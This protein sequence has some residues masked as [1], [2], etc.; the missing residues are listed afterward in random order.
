MGHHQGFDRNARGGPH[1]RFAALVLVVL[2]VLPVALPAGEPLTDAR[3]EQVRREV[4]DLVG[5]LDSS[6]YEVRQRAAQ[7]LD[8]LVATPALATVL[9]EEFQRLVVQPDLPFEARWRLNRW[10][11]RLPNGPATAGRTATPAELDHLVAQIDDDSFAVRQGAVQRLQW[12]AGDATLSGPI[13]LRLKQRMTDPHLSVETYQQLDAVRRTVWSTWLTS[14]STDWNLPSAS[15]E[16]LQRWIDDLVRPAP[17]AAKG[18]AWLR[19]QAAREELMDQL[20]LDA[21]VPKLKAA[22]ESRLSDRLESDAASR[23][24][25]LLDLTR[26]AMVAEFWFARRPSGEQ[27]LFV[28]VPSQVAGALRPSHFDRIDDRVAHCVSGNSLSPGDYPVGVAFPHP[29]QGNAFFHLVNLSTP[30]RQIAYSHYTKTEPAARLTAIS[31]RTL[32]RFLAEKHRLNDAEIGMLGQLDPKE[33]SRFAGQYFLRVD[34]AQIDDDDAPQSVMIGRPRP[35]GQASR[36]GMICAQLAGDGTREA[37]PGLLEAIRQ[38]RFLPPTSLG[39][40]QLHW[41]AALAI[42]RREPWP[43]VESWLVDQLGNSEIM[44]LGRS[45]GPEVG[46]AAAGLLLKRH[47]ERPEAFGLESAPE[48]LLTSFGIAGYRFRS[49]ADARRV[50]AW[51]KKAEG[52]RRKAEVRTRSD[53][54]LRLRN[55]RPL[56][57]SQCT[58]PRP[59][60]LRS[61]KR[62]PSAFRL[63]F[64]S[65]RLT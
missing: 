4:A 1:R 51:W 9:A 21:Q 6:R 27:H 31:R 33:V 62:P 40:Y 39:P 29:A 53:R 20:A 48:S 2:I 3:R 34:D 46:A 50:E 57:A 36:H 56:A 8:E 63:P 49:P 19:Q 37:I 22:L 41:L 61:R 28:G 7:R 16:Q 14:D 24:K 38:K 23:L 47:Q 55:V 25:E 12:L 10:R 60:A 44:V 42:A 5:G 32:D 26:P 13:M 54:R 15:Q 45:E 64:P 30:R 43:E 59:R 35:G 11:T 58:W 65:P 18:Q 52:G 17:K